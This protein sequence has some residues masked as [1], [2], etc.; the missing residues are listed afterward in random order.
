[1]PAAEAVEVAGGRM[2][3]VS[4]TD[5]F[6]RLLPPV[7]AL[8]RPVVYSAGFSQLGI[9]GVAGKHA[10]AAAAQTF[11]HQPL[12]R[13]RQFVLCRHL[14]H[15]AILCQ[16]EGVGHRM[17]AQQLVQ[18]G[19]VFEL[20]AFG[21]FHRLA[22]L[23]HLGRARAQVLLHQPRAARLHAGF[24]NDGKAVAAHIA[25][26][27]V[28][29]GRAG[30]RFDQLRQ[31]VRAGRGNLA[32]YQRHGFMRVFGPLGAARLQAAQFGIALLGLVVQ[33]VQPPAD[34]GQGLQHRGLHRCFA[35]VDVLAQRG[36]LQ[37]EGFEVEGR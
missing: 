5:C 21:V 15:A 36:E 14:A 25:L 28:L 24:D 12:R 27:G 2:T 20:A 9:R 29:P 6:E 13:A 32:L 8:E 18:H 31:Q 35:V 7:R 33:L 26:D 34:V 22:A 37:V 16:Q 30:A 10:V 1:M 23:H 11:F 4:G 3:R 17:R 19:A